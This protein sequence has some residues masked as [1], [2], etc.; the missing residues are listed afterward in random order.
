LKTSVYHK[1]AAELYILSYQ[2]DHPRHI[3]CNIP[4]F[5]LLGAAPLYSNVQDFDTERLNMEMVLLLNGYPP[6]F[7]SYY[8]KRFFIM[9]N[10]TSIWTQ[11]DKE[12]YQKLHQQLL[13]K[14]N[15]R[16]KERQAT[17]D[18]SGNTIPR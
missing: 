11:S 3:H 16:E 8:I 2:S 9:N 4:Y 14:P 12:A 10:G 7:I 1:S 5:A 17:D 6:K 18:S 15:Q 13:H